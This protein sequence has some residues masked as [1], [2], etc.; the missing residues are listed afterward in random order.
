VGRPEILRHQATTSNLGWFLGRRG[1]VLHFVPD[2]TTKVRE[3]VFDK[4]GKSIGAICGRWI[5]AQIPG[6]ASRVRS[7]RCRHCCRLLGLREGQG[8]P[9]NAAAGGSPILASE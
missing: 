3:T 9:L 5:Y 6:V 2:V 1:T 7:D 4:G 8:T